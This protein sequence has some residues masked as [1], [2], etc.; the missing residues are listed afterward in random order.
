MSIPTPFSRKD[1]SKKNNEKKIEKPNVVLSIYHQK[2]LTCQI[3]YESGKN[4]K[5]VKKNK[6]KINKKKRNRKTE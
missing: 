3:W 2:K 5:I 4:L 6:K 1:D